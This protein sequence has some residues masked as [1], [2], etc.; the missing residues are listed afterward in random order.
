MRLE[1]IVFCRGFALWKARPCTVPGT[2]RAL[3]LPSGHV[4]A[5]DNIVEASLASAPDG[6][7]VLIAGTAIDVDT[8]EMQI[9]AISR[10]LLTALRISEETFFDRLDV[11]SG[12]FVIVY[13]TVGSIRV[14]HDACG[15][16]SVFHSAGSEPIV[17]SHHNLIANALTAAPSEIEIA[18]L[19]YKFGYPGRGTPADGVFMLM[20]NCLLDLLTG[21]IHR[22]FPR[23]PVAKSSDVGD[24]VQRV[25]A[26]VSRQLCAVPEKY[27]KVTAS[28]TAG[29]DSR[30]TLATAR[31]FKKAMEYF[32]YR[33]PG[34][35]HDEMDASVAQRIAKQLKLRHHL[36][37]VPCSLADSEEFLHFDRLIATNT[38]YSHLREV[39]YLYWKRYSTESTLHL[40][41]N[42]AEIGR[43]FYRKLGMRRPLTSSTDMTKLFHG[44]L[45]GEAPAEAA[46]ADFFEVTDFGS[47][48]D[49]DP[50]DMF[51]WEHR[52]GTWHALVL[53]E[54]DPAFETHIVFN[55]RRILQA[56][57]S[58]PLEERLRASVFSQVIQ[59]CWPALSKFPFN[60]ED[61]LK[62]YGEARVDI[63]R[64]R[65]SWLVRWPV[66][67]V[68]YDALLAEPRKRGESLE[69]A[70]DKAATNSDAAPH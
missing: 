51:Y 19:P 54:S 63:P 48:Y 45:S 60:P 64:Q 11:L 5:H 68:Q 66:R 56:M 32:T 42:L 17:A 57:L 70:S 39:A 37:Q 1:E 18:K 62:R 44:A 21:K 34:Y 33:R 10:R 35:P 46:F 12:R 52:M 20:P 69:S 26:D 28:L 14:L 24:V 40:R 61:W 50:Y 23:G 13:S 55:A 38:Y 30:F 15:T 25:V 53:I 65:R 2:Y 22:Y 27:S 8:G 41:S 9:A 29:K 31:P 4:F 6:P 43:A 49:Y 3:H 67:G 47:I 7:W 16:R 59:T 36:I 58:L